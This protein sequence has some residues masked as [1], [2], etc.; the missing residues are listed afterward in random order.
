M[1]M[2]DGQHRRRAIQMVFQGDP[3]DFPAD[4]AYSP[5]RLAEAS[6]AL[7]ERPI[8]LEFYLDID[9]GTARGIFGELWAGCRSPSPGRGRGLPYRSP[10]GRRRRRPA[11]R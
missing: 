7:A 5:A 8:S 11:G 10:T 3:A 1:L 6:A 4:D 2:L 9:E